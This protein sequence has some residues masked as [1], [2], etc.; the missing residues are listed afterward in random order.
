MKNPADSEK[1]DGWHKVGMEN[2]PYKTSSQNGRADFARRVGFA[3]SLSFPSKTGIQIILNL[4]QKWK[5]SWSTESSYAA[6]EE[7][8]LEFFI[9]IAVSNFTGYFSRLCLQ[10]KTWEVIIFAFLSQENA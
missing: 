1:S 5:L 10:L 7:L 3:H 4:F 9:D 6:M 8:K 2:H